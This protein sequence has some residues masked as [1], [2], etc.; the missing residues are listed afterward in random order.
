MKLLIEFSELKKKHKRGSP[1]KTGK[2]IIIIAR[3]TQKKPLHHFLSYS[4]F[5]PIL[6]IVYV[7]VAKSRFH[8][9]EEKENKI[10]V[11]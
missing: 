8:A 10:Y 5:V 7:C 1:P 3:Y 2:N 4:L 6:C 9:S 11:F